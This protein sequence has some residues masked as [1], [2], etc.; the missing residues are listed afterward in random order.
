MAALLGST[1]HIP[2]LMLLVNVLGF[3]ALGAALATTLTSLIFTLT[4]FVYIRHF[5]GPHRE[6]WTGW[7][8][9]ALDFR[10]WGS[11]LELA[12]PACVSTCQEWWVY[13]ALVLM[14]G[15]LPHPHVAVAAMAVAMDV[16]S[17]V[18]MLP[19]ALSFAAS[20]R[21]GKELGAGGPA[22]GQTSR[23]SSSMFRCCC[24]PCLVYNH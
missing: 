6:A 17:L 12:T 20:A 8:I 3:G 1:G 10:A 24:G 13:E 16:E 11:L 18:Y 15:S 2:L 5:P 21:I 7:H 14:T 22:S 23:T 9:S 4:L 19:L